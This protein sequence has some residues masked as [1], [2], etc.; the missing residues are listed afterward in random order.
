MSIIKYNPFGFEKESK[1][2]QVKYKQVCSQKQ[3]AF[4]KMEQLM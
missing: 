3:F 1:K 4:N 2:Y